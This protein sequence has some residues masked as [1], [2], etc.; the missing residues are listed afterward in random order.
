MSTPVARVGIDW[1]IQVSA[2]QSSVKEGEMSGQPIEQSPSPDRDILVKLFQEH[3]AHARHCDT[4]RITMAGAFAAVYG[5]VMAYARTN[6]IAWL[7][8]SA[9]SVL[10][11]LISLKTW[12]LFA[13]HTALAEADLEEIGF[14][15][16]AEPDAVVGGLSVLSV[17]WITQF[18]FAALSAVAAGAVLFVLETYQV[19]MS[20]PVPS[21]HAVTAA[22]VVLFALTLVI[23]WA[24]RTLRAT[25]QSAATARRRSSR[26][27]D[28]WRGRDGESGHVS[29]LI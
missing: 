14:T 19:H 21:V 7:L 18:F 8:L 6:P 9:V 17:S 10:G 26:C 1:F 28:F 3:W 24:R 11:M 12:S 13:L 5:V 2:T 29:P 15:F 4:V 23:H 20:G 25:V 27:Q 22:C 16:E